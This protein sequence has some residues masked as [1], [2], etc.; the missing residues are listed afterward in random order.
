MS[1]VRT[2]RE[3]KAKKR[4]RTLAYCLVTV[5][6]ATLLLGILVYSFLPQKSATDNDGSG[7][8]PVTAPQRIAVVDQLSA[9]WP[10]PTF[11]QTAQ[12]ILNQTGLKVDYYSSENV[13]VDFYRNLPSHNYKLIIFRVHSTG[14]TA[15]QGAPPWVVFFTSENYSKTAHVQ[16]QSNMQVVYVK[17]VDS[18]Q[19]YFGIT[20]AFITQSVEGRFNDT[21][22]I[23][24]GC[25]G[26]KYDSMAE[27]FIEKGA[28]DFISWN[29]TVSESFTDTATLS[30]L[31]HLVTEK[32][33]IEE[34]VNETMNEVGPDPAYKSIL[35]FYPDNASEDSL[36]TSTR[37]TTPT[38]AI[39]T[40][41]TFKMKK[42]LKTA[43]PSISSTT[44]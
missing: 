20:P 37:V 36:L 38:I 19:L 10:D 31:R 43:F 5:A 30:L 39:A 15:V 35:M 24:M 18:D 3:A 11:D 6:A 44:M 17:F 23:A 13:T 28:R 16:E 8:Q 41:E 34:A 14:D 42:T 1:T 32:Q 29:G 2:R 40:E 22:I 4:R 12:S 33:N 25:E 21:M 27:A 26:L 9:Q 7:Q